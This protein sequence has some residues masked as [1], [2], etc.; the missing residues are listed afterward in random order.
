MLNNNRLSLSIVPVGGIDKQ[1]SCANCPSACCRA[2]MVIPLSGKEAD[3]IASAGTDMQ[4]LDRHETVGHHAG[5][6]R[7]F[8]KLLS[9]CGNLDIDP[10]TG[11]MQC[12]IWHTKDYPKACNRFTEGSYN[13][14]DVQ[15][16]RIG[17]G[18]DIQV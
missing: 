6:G 5:I 15:L 1:V 13:C 16:T 2:G 10:N 8:Y 4:K 7:K 9:D 3:I 14:V 11:Q 17:S 18:Q 12:K